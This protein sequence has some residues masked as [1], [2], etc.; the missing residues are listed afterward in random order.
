VWLI[1]VCVALLLG[2][3]APME[4]LKGELSRL[5]RTGAS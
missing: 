4:R 2:F 5:G 1:T 3:V